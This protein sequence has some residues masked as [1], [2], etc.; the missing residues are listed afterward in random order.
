[1]K[2]NLGKY[3][4]YEIEEL[5]K[6]FDEG[7]SIYKICRKLNRSQKSIRNNLIRLGKIEGEITPKKNYPNNLIDKKNNI[8]S[9]LCIILIYICLIFIMVVNP[10]LNP[11]DIVIDYLKMIINLF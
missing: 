1:M 2:R 5:I 11:I 7:Y 4:K 10:K 3:R 9:W 6:L 8:N